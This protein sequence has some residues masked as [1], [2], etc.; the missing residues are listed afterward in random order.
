M[1]WKSDQAMVDYGRLPAITDGDF[2]SFG[3]TGRRVGQGN[4]SP[5]C[6]RRRHVK[7]C[8]RMRIQSFLVAKLGLRL[9]VET[10]IK[11]TLGCG[12]KPARTVGQ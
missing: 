10:D 9:W 11:L 3:E 8:L 12:G 2:K 5:A 1:R 4:R 7:D 6:N